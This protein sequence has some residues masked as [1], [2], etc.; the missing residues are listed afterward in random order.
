MDKKCNTCGKIKRIESFGKNKMMKDGIENRCK[1]CKS[2]YQRAYLAKKPRPQAE[3]GPK[4]QGITKN[5]WCVTYELLSI[6]GYD[7]TKDIHLQFAE[8][9][10]VR[11][12]KRP[13]RNKI[14]YPPT[15]CLEGT[16]MA[17]P[18]TKQ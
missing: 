9:Y 15:D 8:K 7:I 4:L 13:K 17:N 2:N 14:Q 16:D 3:S 12:K 1:I 10:G 18:L 11:Y 5:D 6:M